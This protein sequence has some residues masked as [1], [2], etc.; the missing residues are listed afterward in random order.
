VLFALKN[1][2]QHDVCFNPQEWWVGMPK[3][4]RIKPVLHGI[5]SSQD[6]VPDNVLFRAVNQVQHTGQSHRR[7]IQCFGSI[8]GVWVHVGAS[9]Q[10]NRHLRVLQG[11]LKVTQ[12]GFK[13]MGGRSTSHGSHFF[14]VPLT[15]F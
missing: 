13:V 7:L 15:F 2:V 6:T 9:S 3:P 12:G 11:V 8:F 5:G 14:T 10:F 1:T 4:S